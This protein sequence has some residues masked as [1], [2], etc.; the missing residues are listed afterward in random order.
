MEQKRKQGMM[1]LLIFLLPFAAAVICIGIG[2]YNI[3]PAESLGILLSPL[4]GREVD[5]QGWSVIYHVRLPRILLALAVGMG[6]SV[7]GASFQSL[8]SNPLATPDT[9]GVATGA[10]FGAVLALFIYQKY[11][12]CSAG[13]PAH[14]TGG[15]GRNVPDQPAQW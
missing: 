4:T 14:G 13:C 12:R 3:S 11:S 2:R 15:A 9:L 5:P 10:S 1:S 6:L 8:F 7:S